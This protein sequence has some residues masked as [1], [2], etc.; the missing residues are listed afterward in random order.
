MSTLAQIIGQS[1]NNTVE[2][3]SAVLDAVA[4]YSMDLAT[5]VAASDVVINDTVCK[6]THRSIYLILAI[7]KKAAMQSIFVIFVPVYRLL[8]IWS[9]L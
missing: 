7:G 5:F 1:E 4:D 8:M 2:Q 6:N 3:N 9:R